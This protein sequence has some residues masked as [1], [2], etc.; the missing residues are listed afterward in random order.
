MGKIDSI[1]GYI[2]ASITFGPISGSGNSATITTETDPT[3]YNA[4][5]LG[6]MVTLESAPTQPLT[7]DVKYTSRGVPNAS[8][9]LPS[10]VTSIPISAGSKT[11]SAYTLALGDPGTGI[12]NVT[13]LVAIGNVGSG[14][15]L[16]GGTVI[17]YNKLYNSMDDGDGDD[18]DAPDPAD[19]DASDAGS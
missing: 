12:V 2:P 9:I 8:L 16:G 15:I 17:I 3:A 19:P 1:P 4:D 18:S 5:S 14:M 11:S 6:F 13:I 10:N 7:L